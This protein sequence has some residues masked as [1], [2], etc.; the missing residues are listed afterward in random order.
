MYI[1]NVNGSFKKSCEKTESR[2]WRGLWQ[3]ICDIFWGR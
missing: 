2:E 1:G 3:F